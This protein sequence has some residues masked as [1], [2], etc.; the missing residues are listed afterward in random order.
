MGMAAWQ[1]APNIASASPPLYHH[2][3][4]RADI[5]VPQRRR[6]DTGIWSAVRRPR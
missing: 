1:I 4:G 5:P 2:H 3:A 6:A